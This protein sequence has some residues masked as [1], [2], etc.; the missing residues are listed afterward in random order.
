MTLIVWFFLSGIRLIYNLH[1]SATLQCCWSLSFQVPESWERYVKPYL[2]LFSSF[3]FPSFQT[4]KKKGKVWKLKLQQHQHWLLAKTRTT[5]ST[6]YVDKTMISS[7]PQIPRP[8]W[9]AVISNSWG[10]N[11]C[12]FCTMGKAYLCTI[13]FYLLNQLKVFFIL[14]RKFINYIDNDWAYNRRVNKFLLTTLIAILQLS[15]PGLFVNISLV[16]TKTKRLIL[17]LLLLYSLKL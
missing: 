2:Q 11:T 17:T 8:V 6:N 16:K 3:I 14:K 9:L 7:P 1:K 4:E 5:L 15:S 13:V 12:V 10:I